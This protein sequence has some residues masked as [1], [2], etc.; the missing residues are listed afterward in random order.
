MHILPKPGQNY[1][2]CFVLFFRAKRWAINLRRE[3]LVNREPEYMNKNCTVCSEHFEDIMF[4]NDLRN[5]LQPTA[6]PTIVHV[7]NPPKLVTG[8]RCKPKRNSPT[9]SC[10]IGSAK[11]KKFGNHL[12][13]LCFWF[14]VMCCSLA[15]SVRFVQSHVRA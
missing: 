5:R 3:D 2:L 10:D 11:R 1:L 8:S 12:Y 13:R 14:I 6:V 15:L 4:L 7:S 9:D